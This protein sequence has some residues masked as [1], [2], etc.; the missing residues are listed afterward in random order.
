M[1]GQTSYNFNLGYS[2]IGGQETF[3]LLKYTDNW[4][5]VVVVKALHFKDLSEPNRLKSILTSLISQDLGDD[6]LKYLV[7]TQDVLELVSESVCWVKNDGSL[8]LDFDKICDYSKDCN[9][10]F[11]D[12]RVMKSS[13][14]LFYRGRDMLRLGKISVADHLVDLFEV[15]EVDIDKRD[16]KLEAIAL[17]AYNYG[18][19][20]D[21][22]Y[23]MFTT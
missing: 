5:D 7:L 14:N 19:V 2:A 13:D 15:S 17:A 6:K 21:Y 10:G 20:P 1:T 8:G 18:I 12:M 9:L 16:S 22:M 3:V 11:E 23:A 4:D